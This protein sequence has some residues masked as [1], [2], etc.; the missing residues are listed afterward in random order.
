MAL[1]QLHEQNNKHI[2]SVSGATFLIN[3]QGGS[4]LVRWELCRS[5]LCRI[6]EEFEGV[7]SLT[8]HEIKR[9]HHEDSPTFLN[10]FIKDTTTLLNNLP[11]N[12]FLLNDLP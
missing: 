3:Q 2:K 12:P 11:N 9:K 5:E 10:D 4:A 7:E 6:T 8:T 1:D